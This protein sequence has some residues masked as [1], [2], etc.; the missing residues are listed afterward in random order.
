M[1]RQLETLGC[2]L[3]SLQLPLPTHFAHGVGR[4]FQ[5]NHRPKITFYVKKQAI[6]SSKQY[7]QKFCKNSENKIWPKSWLAI[8]HFNFSNTC[9]P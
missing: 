2:F 5:S 4:F 7:K 1:M 6:C 3:L 8:I 9:P